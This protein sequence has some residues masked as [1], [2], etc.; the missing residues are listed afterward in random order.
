MSREARPGTVICAGAFCVKQKRPA[1]ILN[2]LL[3]VKRDNEI[4]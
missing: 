1:G 3:P 4:I 2:E